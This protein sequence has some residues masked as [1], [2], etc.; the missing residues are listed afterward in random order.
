MMRIHRDVYRISEGPAMHPL[1]LKAQ[2]RNR[3]SLMTEGGPDKVNSGE[4]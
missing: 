3:S 1:I 4:S 2:H